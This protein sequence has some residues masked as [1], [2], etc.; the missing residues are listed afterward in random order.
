MKNERR[1]EVFQ[2]EKYY[3][4]CFTWH[5]AIEATFIIM[6]SEQACRIRFLRNHGVLT[7]EDNNAIKKKEIN[8]HN[9]RYII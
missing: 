6:I 3:F 1:E 2:F 7:E 8:M 5:L 9:S 4:A